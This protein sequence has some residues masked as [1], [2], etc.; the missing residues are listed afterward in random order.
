MGTCWLQAIPRRGGSTSSA[1][2]RVLWTYGPASGPGSLDHPSLAQALPN[3]MIAVT[4]DLHDRVVLIDRA[5]KRIVWQ[6]GHDGTPG[7]A[8]GYLNNP[9]GLQ[10]VP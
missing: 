4:D 2:G 5:T 3:G 7:S 10:L 9:D 1:R 8:P 6:Y